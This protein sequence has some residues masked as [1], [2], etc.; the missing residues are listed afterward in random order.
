MRQVSVVGIGAGD[1]DDLTIK[2]VN[3]LKRSD[4]LFFPAKGIDGG[5]LLRARREIAERHVPA[6]GHRVGGI[7]DPKRDPSGER[8]AAGVERWYDRRIELWED[9]LRRHL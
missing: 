4:V 5:E 3:A 6:G 9:A 2:A 8:Y 1:P 7:P